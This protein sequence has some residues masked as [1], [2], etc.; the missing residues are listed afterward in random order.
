MRAQILM[1][2]ALGDAYAREA[3][4]FDTARADML[5][6]HSRAHL[7]AADGLDA[8]LRDMMARLASAPAGPIVVLDESGGVL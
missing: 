7:R 5:R 8:E 2:R 4:S 1:L 6:A 3:D